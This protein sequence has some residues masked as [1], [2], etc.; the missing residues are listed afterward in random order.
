VKT[1]GQFAFSTCE[2]LTSVTIPNSVETIGGAAFDSCERLTSVTIPDSVET[3]GNSAFF[4]CSRL[5]DITFL[6]GEAPSILEQVFADIALSGTVRYPAG[7]KEAYEAALA[8]ARLPDGWTHVLT[9]AEKPEPPKPTDPPRLPDYSGSGNNDSGNSSYTPPRTPTLAPKHTLRKGDGWYDTLLGKAVEVRLYAD[10]PVMGKTTGSET[11]NIRGVFQKWFSNQVR[12]I[13]FDQPGKWER[14]ISVAAKVDLTGMDTKRLY[15][16]A[17][18]PNTNS[19]KRLA[20]PAYWL[21]AN[22]YLHF[23]T[24]Y[25]GEIIISEGPLIK[26]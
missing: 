12:V 23:T 13:H 2:K 21:D 7:A 8:G 4:K 20:S 16:Y 17:Y 9:D 10:W 15:F 22:G 25:A 19:Y 26:R 14:A 24:E 1:I 11:S 5:D 3:I 6:G 18:N